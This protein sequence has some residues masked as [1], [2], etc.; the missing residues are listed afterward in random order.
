MEA[1]GWLF[2]TPTEG[3]SKLRERTL[4][5]L[6]THTKSHDHEIFKA[7][8]NLPKAILWNIKYVNMQLMGLKLIVN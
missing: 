5:P 4:E 8:E 2:T 3:E 7:L 6:D 1:H